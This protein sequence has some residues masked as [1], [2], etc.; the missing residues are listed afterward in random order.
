MIG[1][2]FEIFAEKVSLANKRV[3]G[4]I[5]PEIS[6]VHLPVAVPFLQNSWYWRVLFKNSHSNHAS[7]QH[8]PYKL[9]IV[10]ITITD[11]MKALRTGLETAFLTC[12]IFLLIAPP[13]SEG[14]YTI[15]VDHVT[16]KSHRILIQSAY[17]PTFICLFS[18]ENKFSYLQTT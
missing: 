10:L 13:W 7:L 8:N 15:G 6:H 2:P 14:Q 1:T 4:K 12:L 3:F 5:V 16:V 18:E 9:D 17:I 11:T